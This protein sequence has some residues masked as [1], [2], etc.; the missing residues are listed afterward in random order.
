M[1]YEEAK[2]RLENSACSIAMEEAIDVAIQALEKQI[3]KKPK[4]KTRFHICPVCE[5]PTVSDYCSRCGQALDWE[6]N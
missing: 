5:A 2:Q 4:F 3:P 1:I 6:G